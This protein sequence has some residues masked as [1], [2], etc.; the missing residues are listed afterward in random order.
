MKY[1]TRIQINLPRNKVI[2]LFDNTENMFKWQSGLQSFNHLSGEPGQVGARSKLIYKMGRREVEMVETITKR[3]FPDEFH[4]TYEAK[5]V[6]NR[7]ENYFEETSDSNTTWITIS[8]FKCSGFM[9]IMC[10][11]MPGAFKKQT[12]KYMNQFKKFS[13]NG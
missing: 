7:Q 12:L 6:W 2:E 4:G 11:L 5:N 9:K 8:E 1:T 3:Q 13:E 10:W